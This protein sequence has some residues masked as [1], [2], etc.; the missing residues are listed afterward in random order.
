LNALDRAPGGGDAGANAHFVP[1]IASPKARLIPALVVLVPTARHT[2]AL[3]HET[4]VS[5]FRVP[6]GSA[7][8][9]RVQ[10]TPFHRKASV[11]VAD[12]VR[13]SPTATHIFGLGHDTAARL[14]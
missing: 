6:D 7:L 11:V 14:S 8:V 2:V 3:G 4:P 5:P 1:D 12:D 9:I 13:T 10:A